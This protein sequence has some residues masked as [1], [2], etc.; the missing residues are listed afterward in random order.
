MFI[1]YL[2]YFRSG[3]QIEIGNQIPMKNIG[4]VDFFSEVIQAKNAN[5]N[6]AY[7]VHFYSFL[8]A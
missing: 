4:R 6:I 7:F 3:P 8:A 1:C 2:N 5:W